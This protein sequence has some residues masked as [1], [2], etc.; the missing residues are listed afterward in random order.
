MALGSHGEENILYMF[1][2][3]VPCKLLLFSWLETRSGV[4]PLRTGGQMFGFY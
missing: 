1:R 3:H 4:G 2:C